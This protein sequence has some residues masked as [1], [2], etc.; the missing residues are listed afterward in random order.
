MVGDFSVEVPGDFR[1]AK[2]QSIRPST[3]FFAHVSQAANV[4]RRLGT[5]DL[6]F[7]EGIAHS[8]ILLLY[9]RVF[10]IFFVLVFFSFAFVLGLDGV[11][12]LLLDLVVLVVFIVL[13]V[14]G[15][16]VFGGWRDFVGEGL[17]VE[18]LKRGRRRGRDE[19]R[20]VLGNNEVSKIEIGRASCRERVLRL[21]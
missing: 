7:A 12:F 1:P 17:V 2:G 8:I 6:G 19:L 20:I 15:L 9:P 13:V 3:Q 10:F 21:V 16:A 18:R 14:S 11:V 4:P 5:G